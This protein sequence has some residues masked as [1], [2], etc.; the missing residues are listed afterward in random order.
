[1]P[2]HERLIGRTAELEQLGTLL[3]SDRPVV[4]VGEAGVGKT[5]LIRDA[6]LTDGREAFE[7][8]ALSTLS[9][10]P[11]LPI[12]RALGAAPG[13]TDAESVAQFV[14]HRLGP[15]I[16]MV[17]DLQWADGATL[18][19]LA[20]LVGT[21]SVV[22]AVRT[23]DPESERVLVALAQSG[24][25]RLDLA[26]L[27][28]ASSAEVV[29]RRAP[30]MAGARV[31]R[32][33]GRSGG[34]PLLLT[35]LAVDEEPSADLRLALEARVRKLTAAARRTFGLLALAGRPMPLRGIDPVTTEEL[36]AAGLG[37]I[38]GSEMMARHA[39][40]AET[41]LETLSAGERR[42]LHAELADRLD[43]AGEVARHHAA[44]GNRRAAH[45]AAL[46]AV[47][48]AMLPGERAEHLAIAAETAGGAQAQDLRLRAAQALGDIGAHARAISLV[49]DIEIRDPAELAAIE[50]LR[51]N[52]ARHAGD[53][54]TVAQACESAIGRAAGMASE[55]EVRLR[56]ACAGAALDNALM[57]QG[58][59]RVARAQALQATASAERL[60][61]HRAEARLTLGQVKLMMR[62]PGW[63]ENLLLAAEAAHEVGQ[64]GT[65]F[66]ARG[67]LAFGLLIEGR[68]G[69]AGE[70][71]M[72]LAERARALGLPGAERAARAQAVGAMWHA[73]GPATEVLEA[74]EDLVTGAGNLAARRTIAF[75]VGQAFADAG[76]LDE[77]R[78]LVDDLVAT[79][80]PSWDDLGN[81]LWCRTDVE[82]WSG[83]AQEAVTAAD[84]ALGR[85]G[86][87]GP[88]SFLQVSRAWALVDIG[89]VPDH[90]PDMD[91]RPIIAGAIPEVEA[92][93]SLATGH[94]ADAAA[95]FRRAAVAWAGRHM[96]G[97]LRSRWGEGEALR[98]NGAP[99]LAVERLLKVEADAERLGFVPL[100]GRI[101][102]SLRL[103]GVRRS[104]PRRVAAGLTGRERELLGLA[105]DGHTSADIAR[106]LGVGRPTVDRIIA[107]AML[108]LGADTRAQAAA[109]ASEQ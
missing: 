7:G 50:L 24:F 51:V 109:L 13:S 100:L 41:Y 38:D 63:R 30:T 3:E 59:R 10:M 93:R 46:R 86:R 83:R 6:V 80:H 16:L 20:L 23:G 27:D 31:E 33:V 35:E 28:A 49:A 61:R 2:E 89:R 53:Y 75:Y 19:V 76:R 39:L 78:S 15:G 79:A 69:D 17:D 14:E 8:G 98:R 11:Y 91:D 67:R 1:M 25:A 96:R 55:I 88:T 29:R 108:K 72:A 70:V 32:I 84:E 56:I 73:S 45:G 57:F 26:P 66:T 48:E 82:Y 4:V 5:S 74:A 92:L 22:T 34:N 36:R 47:E 87:T 90:V 101:R 99:S 62:E 21:T 94:H 40:I 58:D 60:G 102:R 65:E 105:G 106:R 107:S 42:A 9:W 68:P 103:L 97:E 104:V 52:A 37:A 18:E 95:L 54:A 85:F 77:A 44:A 81:A 71:A 12:Q 43:D 64:V